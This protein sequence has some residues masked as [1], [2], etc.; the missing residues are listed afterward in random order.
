MAGAAVKKITDTAGGL[1]AGSGGPKPP[2][3]LS[4]A[5]LGMKI[6]GKVQPCP[7]FDEGPT[8]PCTCQSVS[9]HSSHHAV[10]HH[11]CATCEVGFAVG[12]L[13]LRFLW[14]VQVRF[15]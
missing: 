3:A 6:G 14:H 11:G 15:E 2:P 1:F 10:P 13:N 4:S 5:V 9:W 12:A 7:V 8:G